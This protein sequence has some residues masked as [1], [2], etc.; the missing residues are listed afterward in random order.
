MPIRLCFIAR[1][2]GLGYFAYSAHLQSEVGGIL[3][4]GG[5]SVVDRDKTHAERTEENSNH[6]IA[7]ESYEDV[8]ALNTPEETGV[9]QYVTVTAF[10]I[11]SYSC[12]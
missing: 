6:L 8:Q 12:G 7:H 5:G 3:Q 2:E 4:E 10:F 9:F 11:H 1:V